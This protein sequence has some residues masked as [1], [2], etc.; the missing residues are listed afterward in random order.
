MRLLPSWGRGGVSTPFF[1]FFFIT[2]IPL[3]LAPVNLE[4]FQSVKWSAWYLFICGAGVLFR[5]RLHS[6]P[7]IILIPGILMGVSYALSM[8]ANRGT[9]I[10]V[11]VDAIGIVYLTLLSYNLH[12]PSGKETK[13]IDWGIFVGCIIASIHSIVQSFG[14][15]F[16]PAFGLN[17]SGHASTI[18]HHNQFSEYLVW[19]VVASVYLFTGKY[20]KFVLF[21]LILILTSLFIQNSRSLMLSLGLAFIPYVV[22]R[23]RK[24]FNK[25]LIFGVLAV[26]LVSATLKVDTLLEKK[27]WEAKG[28]QPRLVMLANAYYVI[29]DNWALGIGPENYMF[30]VMPYVDAYTRDQEIHEKKVTRAPHNGF[31]EGF[32]ESGIGFFIGSLMLFGVLFVCALIS[33][34]R[35]LNLTVVSLI[36]LMVFFNFPMESAIGSLFIPIFVGRVLS[37]S[38]VDQQKNLGTLGILFWVGFSSLFFFQFYRQFVSG[39]ELVRDLTGLKTAERVCYLYPDH[40]KNCTHASELAVKLQKY[41]KAEQFAMKELEARP[42]NFPAIRSLGMAKMYQKDSLGGCRYLG[43][44]ERLMTTRYTEPENLV[45]RSA[46][47]DRSMVSD[48]FEKVCTP[49]N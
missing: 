14:I 10:T 24:F 9:Y 5:N 21:G 48:F 2:L 44:Y 12:V 38:M 40:W 33:W 19:G 18:G 45:L 30:G 27:V 17:Y 15:D 49:G 39:Y 4:A 42:Y 36:F 35:G 13:A 11:T 37:E 31:V 23:G 28:T 29:K 7:S 43:I 32:A 25:K 46:V 20:K 34:R 3:V 26:L 41:G 47:H 1:I 16:L 22:S 8:A 6:W